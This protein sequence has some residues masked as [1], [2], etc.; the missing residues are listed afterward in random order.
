MYT[1]GTTGRPKGVM[2]T[3]ATSG[4]N[5]FNVDSVV[6]T[7]RSD[8]NLAVAPLFHIGCL[9]SFTLRSLAR[10]GATLV[11]RSFEPGA[12]PRGP[13]RVPGQHHLRGARDVLRR[14]PAAA[15]R[16]R[17]PVAAAVGD[18]SGG[19]RAA[20]SWSGVRPPRCR[21]AA[22]V[23][24][25]RDRAVRDVAATE[26]TLERASSAGL[27]MPFCEIKIVDPVTGANAHRAQRGR[28]D[29]RAGTER[30]RATWATSRHGRR[31]RRRELV[32]LRRPGVSR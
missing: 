24:A 15:V 9:N 28:R 5:S 29:L 6:E 4:G 14:R 8:V 31:V 19:A 13:R 25:D 10:G 1:S 22:G 27:P 11:R 26:R 3:P 23:G 32:P 7:S 20:E 17:G 16:R 30:D 21:A 12:D 18:R 2:L